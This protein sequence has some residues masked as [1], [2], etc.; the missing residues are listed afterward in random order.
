MS[1]ES[2]PEPPEQMRRWLSE[3]RFAPFLAAAGGDFTDARR[4]Y[5][6]N[7]QIAGA[8]FEV[9]AHVEVV[10]RNAIHQQLKRATA[11]NALHSWLTDADV[12]QEKQIQ[13]VQEA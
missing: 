4:L 1:A 6:W 3:R 11:D 7:G 10:V 5:E 13:A 9:V 2:T 8:L 12:L